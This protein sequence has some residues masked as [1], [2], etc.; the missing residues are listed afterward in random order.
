MGKSGVRN[1]L[2]PPSRQVK[3]FK[4]PLPLLKGGKPLGFRMAKIFSLPPPFCR[5]KQARKIHLKIWSS[6][7]DQDLKTGRP[8]EFLIVLKYIVYA[9]Q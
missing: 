4:H 2:H 5:G 9:D 7:D 8:Q 1:Y 6:E 3:L